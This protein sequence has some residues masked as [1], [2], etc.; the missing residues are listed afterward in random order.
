M[1][2]W[3]AR[4]REIESFKVMDLLKRAKALDSEGHDVDGHEHPEAFSGDPTL[5][6]GGILAKALTECLDH[7]R[8]LLTRLGNKHGEQTQGGRIH[9]FVLD[10]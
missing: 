1:T 4:A 7:Q 5:F 6:G 8:E 2:S 10:Q 9:D 3:S